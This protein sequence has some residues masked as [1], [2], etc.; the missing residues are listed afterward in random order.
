MPTP[1]DTLPPSAP[2]ATAIAI[3]GLLGAGVAVFFSLVVRAFAC[4]DGDC[5]GGGTALLVI[6]CAGVL[7]VIAMLIESRRRRGHPWY[8]FVAGAVVYA[9]WGVV[10]TSVVG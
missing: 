7:P 8:W 1:G 10:F 4:E 2:I 5:S 6:A 9:F 3:A